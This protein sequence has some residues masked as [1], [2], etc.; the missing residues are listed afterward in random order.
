MQETANDIITQAE[1]LV[2]DVIGYVNDGK[3]YDS[4]RYLLFFINNIIILFMD[5]YE[6]Q[7]I[8]CD[9]TLYRCHRHHFRYCG[10]IHLQSQANLQHVITFIILIYQLL[11][12]F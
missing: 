6:L 7:R 4:K 9:G 3:D 10:W 2:N 12:I 8:G 5:S 11:M 1:D